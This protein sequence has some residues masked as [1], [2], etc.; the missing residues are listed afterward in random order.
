ME[1][2]KEKIAYPKYLDEYFKEHVVTVKQMPDKYRVLKQDSLPDKTFKNTRTFVSYVKSEL[3]FWSYEEASKNHMVKHYKQDFEQALTNL[4]EALNYDENNKSR[5]LSYLQYAIN[6]V[7]NTAHIS[8]KT[9]LAK[10]LKKHKDKTTFFFY[11]FEAAISPETSTSYTSYS[12]WQEG[13]YYGIQYR[14]AI[15][16]IEK[17]IQEYK[18]S[19]I[20]AAKEAEKK[21]TTIIEDTTTLY[22]TQEEKFNSLFDSNNQKLNQQHDETN[23]FIVEKQ[24]QMKNLEAT[25]GEKLKL[26]QPAK[27]WKDMSVDYQKSAFGWLATSCII[28]VIIIIGLV[29]LVMNVSNLFEGNKAIV[30]WIKETAMVTVLTGIALYILR[31]TVKLSMSSF[32]LSR[33]AK[34][35]EQ[36]TY[37][38][39]SLT[40]EAVIS[41]KERILVI[42]SLFSRSDTGLLK[43]DSSPV[44]TTNVADLFKDK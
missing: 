34:E 7:T 26:S 1:E 25:Y 36:L 33:D 14:E 37:F 10:Q 11:G 39:L 38:Y 5:A 42:N 13:F 22:H 3:S 23:N 30:D 29:F 40:K 35:R 2:Q 24:E 32:H 6:S 31:I 20:E 43:G 18:T 16:S 41:D 27:Y 17:A 44:M 4:N 15:T 28:A 12:S 19:Y 9:E 21:L 8:S